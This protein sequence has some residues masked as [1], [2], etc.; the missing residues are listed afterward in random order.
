MFGT[1][2]SKYLVPQSQEWG[3]LTVRSS[4]AVFPVPHTVRAE[5]QDG[6]G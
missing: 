6:L 5:S 4:G 2:G 3:S 1:T